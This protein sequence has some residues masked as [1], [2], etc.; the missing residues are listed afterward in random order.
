MFNFIYYSFIKTNLSYK[1]Q[2]IKRNKEDIWINKKRLIFQKSSHLLFHHHCS[3]HF[4]I[5]FAMPFFY[6]ENPL[7]SPLKSSKNKFWNHLYFLSFSF[8]VIHLNPNFPISTRLPLLSFA[9]LLLFLF[10]HRPWKF[11][12]IHIF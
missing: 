12:Q 8:I 10:Y 11:F 3:F 2:F 1:L 6:V 5:F 4:F 7:P 9:E